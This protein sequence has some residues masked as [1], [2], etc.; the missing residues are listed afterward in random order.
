MTP[1]EALCILEEC[2]LDDTSP[3]QVEL[4]AIAELNADTYGPQTGDRDDCPPFGIP[5]RLRIVPT[6]GDVA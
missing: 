1:A 3:Y 6:G 2:L 5:R 4:F